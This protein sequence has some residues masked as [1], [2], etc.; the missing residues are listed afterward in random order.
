M[1][2]KVSAAHPISLPDH[3]AGGL[4]EH[5][6]VYK[7]DYFKC[8]KMENEKT[9]ATLVAT[10][11]DQTKAKRKRKRKKGALSI[12]TPIDAQLKKVRTETVNVSTQVPVHRKK[13][14]GTPKKK[15]GYKPFTVFKE[16]EGE[17]GNYRKL[18]YNSPK[19]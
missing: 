18:I 4:N 13:K 9:G 16:T 11:T 6:N 2:T 5:F 15:I 17:E 1:Y 19:Y 3:V 7:N 12:Q 10:T 8:L 14:K